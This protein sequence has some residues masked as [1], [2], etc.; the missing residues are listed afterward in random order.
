MDSVGSL[1]TISSDHH[2]P[3]YHS[4]PKKEKA[5]SLVEQMEVVD[6][7]WREID[8]QKRCE[9]SLSV[10]A[11][12]FVKKGISP[13]L[14]MAKKILLKSMNNVRATSVTMEQYNQIFCKNIFKDALINVNEAIEQSNKG[15][16]ETPL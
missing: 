6:E 9:V 11:G 12:L 1:P 10:A 3:S 13:D 2:R 7:W 15:A 5:P 14:E 8:P 16:T 4:L